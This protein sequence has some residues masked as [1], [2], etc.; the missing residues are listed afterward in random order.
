[1]LDEY[2][3]HM[4]SSP[5][6][7]RLLA[8]IQSFVVGRAKLVIV[9][10]NY[11]KSVVE[12]WGIPSDKIR[13]IYSSLY[14]LSVNGSRDEI[15]S[16]LE[17]KYPTIISA[18]R[19]VPWKGFDV[20]IDVIDSLRNTF[21]DITL[22]IAGDGEDRVKLGKKAADLNL[23][24]HIKFIGSISKDT[25]GATIKAADVFV[26]NTAY[27]GLSHQ[28]IEVMDIGTAIVT[29]KAGGNPELIT[30]GVNG[31]LVDFNNVEQ[32]TESITR[33]LNHPESRERMVQSARGFSK[34]FAKEKILEKIV[35]MLNEVHGK[36]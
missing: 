16:R 31:F 27:E 33:V 34:E 17:Y 11:L 25:L 22:I 30:D 3:E 26:L 1:M 21:P 24:E 32:L 18:G 15:R 12:K 6:P 4:D 19:L 7:V 13:V 14:P 35:A 2:L 8:K 9:P 23:R 28:L 36:R 5:L 29:T 10:S 20:L